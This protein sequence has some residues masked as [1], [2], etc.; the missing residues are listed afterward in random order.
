MLQMN[1]EHMHGDLLDLG[2]G[3][4]KYKP[5]L[6]KQVGSYTAFDMVEGPNVDVVGDIHNLPFEDNSF[7][8][9]ISTSVMEHVKEPWR[10]IEE[11]QRVL[12]PGGKCILTTPFMVPFHADPND[13]YRYT[14]EGGKHLFERVGLEIIESIKYGGMNVVMA[15]M[16]KFLF[17]N[18]Y[19]HT[20][21]GFLRRNI[22][23]VVYKF[24]ASLSKNTK[25]NA[26]VYANICIV[27]QAKS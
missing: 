18:P 9:I 25:Q 22:F 16:Y 15:E 4:A 3:K 14:T 20:K 26:S 13:Y 7:D 17:C 24:L 1:F 8:T 12:R 2:S 19:I 5:M 27:A 10:M 23:R 6:L 11:V 21:P